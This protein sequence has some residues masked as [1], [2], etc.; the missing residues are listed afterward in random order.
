MYRPSSVPSHASFR[1]VDST[2]RGLTQDFCTA[3]NTGNYD[4]SA[5]FFSSEGVFMAPHRDMVQGPKAIERAFQEYGESGYQDLRLE[6]IRI[7]HSGD[8]ATEVGRYTLAV[9]L[10]N[11]TTFAD[12]G[13]YVHTWRRLGAW[14]M[15]VDCWNSNLPPVK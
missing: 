1:D 15:T 7:E 14:L 6:T 12:R 10:A 3:F 2:I 9:K 5:A 13:K 11:G 8:M 4:Q